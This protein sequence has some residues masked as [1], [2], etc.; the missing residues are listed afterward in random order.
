MRASQLFALFAMQL[1]V[2]ACIPNTAVPSATTAPPQATPQTVARELNG[3]AASAVV[4][5]E[6]SAELAFT[7]AAPVRQLAVNEGDRVQEG[8]PLIVLSAPDLE[9]AVTGADAAL[10]SAQVNAELQRY[11]HKVQ[12]RA[13]KFIYLT[14]PPE[15]RQAADARVVQ[16]QAALAVAR[17]ELARATLRAPF[18]GT[19]IAVPFAVGEL[20][21]PNAS[22]L[23]LADLENLQIETTDLS[24]RDITHVRLGQKAMVH[25]AA[26]DASFPGIVSAI[27]PRGQA[28]A[29]DVLFHVTITLDEQP[30][31]LLWGMSA[32][33]TI[34]N[35]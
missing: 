3:V 12:N 1:V 10:R 5:P 14:G 27:A 6:R 2:T 25:V 16:A 8:Q 17:G 22:V 31:R 26:L 29:G 21:Q 13:G 7:L 32:Q 15:V 4:V 23:T 11:S 35:N 30:P 20:V 33:V 24:E 28:V 19:V 9:F 34:L 18:A